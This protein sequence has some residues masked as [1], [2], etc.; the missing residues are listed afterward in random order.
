LLRYAER[1]NGDK[2]ERKSS[3]QN[4]RER[5]KSELTERY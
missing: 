4:T 5:L 1:V 2:A 3:L